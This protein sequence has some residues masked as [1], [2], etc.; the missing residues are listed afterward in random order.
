MFYD[1]QTEDVDS[2]AFQQEPIK[3]MVTSAE[4]MD[5]GFWFGRTPRFN[6]IFDE[7][8]KTDQ[9]NEISGM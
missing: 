2:L 4:W 1:A 6:P 8:R 3:S 7:A 9:T 5:H